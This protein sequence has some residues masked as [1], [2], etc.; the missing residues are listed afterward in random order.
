MYYSLEVLW[1]QTSILE[2]N[3]NSTNLN[4]VG[5]KI[6]NKAGK[7]LGF[8]TA[9]CFEC[10]GEVLLPPG[11]SDSWNRFF[12]GLVY[13]TID[14]CSLDF[15]IETAMQLMGKQ[16]SISLGANGDMSFNI[17][18]NDFYTNDN[19]YQYAYFKSRRIFCVPSVILGEIKR[20][21]EINISL[22]EFGHV[23]NANRRKIVPSLF[24]SSEYAMNVSTSICL[25]DYFDIMSQTSGQG[26]VFRSRTIARRLVNLAFIIQIL[27]PFYK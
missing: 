26:S 2:T 16:L 9:G 5:R 24:G 8:K 14:N 10:S 1:N 21:P 27:H 3:L 17:S 25:V 4:T 6:Y 22:A 13:N 19:L 7:A 11:Q 15:V 12:L 23:T 18:R 20:C